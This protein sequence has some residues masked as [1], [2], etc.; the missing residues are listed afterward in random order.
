MGKSRQQ[1]IQE[2]EDAKLALLLD[3]YAEIYGK[4]SADLYEKDV[5]DGKVIAV[6]EQDQET[7]LNEILR[8]AEA[9]ERKEARKGTHFKGAVRKI[10]TVAAAIAIVILMMVSVQAAGVDIFGAIGKWTNSLFHF[11]PISEVE[12]DLKSGMDNQDSSSIE[13]IL[14]TMVLYGFPM[15]LAPSWLPEDYSLKTVTFPENS[16]FRGVG[17]YLEST[18][19]DWLMIQIDI[20]ATTNGFVSGWIEKDEEAAESLLSQNKQFYLFQNDSIWTGAYQSESHRITIVDSRGKDDLI[21]IIQ[22][23]GGKKDE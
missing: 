20:A 5:A 12:P 17:F 18:T 4:V 21:Q 13:E 14:K 1:L 6:S 7:Q 3:E 16:D 19:G 9:D 23:L 22:S 15:D 8:R 2:Y 11:E 10:T